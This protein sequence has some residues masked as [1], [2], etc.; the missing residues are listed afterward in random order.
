M[1]LREKEI[2]YTRAG[3]ILKPLEGL[4]K[5]EC[6]QALE[7]AI[8]I[9]DNHFNGKNFSI[10]AASL[11]SRLIEDARSAEFLFKNDGH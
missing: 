5:L 3:E 2:L 9:L 11:V 6:T 4:S 10:E 7:Q 8:K 1:D